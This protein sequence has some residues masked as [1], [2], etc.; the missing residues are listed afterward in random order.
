[1]G[2]IR[3]FGFHRGGRKAQPQ[4][5]AERYQKNPAEIEAL[6]RQNACI[7]AERRAIWLRPAGQKSRQRQ[8]DA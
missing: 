8:D 2:R 6:K 1:M 4:T 5:M 3:P 7:F